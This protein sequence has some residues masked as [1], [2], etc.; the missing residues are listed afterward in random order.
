MDRSR[1]QVALF[2]DGDNLRGQSWGTL[3]DHAREFGRLAIARLYMDFQILSDGGAAARAA[4][5]EPVHVLG[6]K[7]SDGFK[8]MVDVALACDAMSVLHE[9]ENITTL[10]VG[11]GDADF[12]PLVVN[13]K[14]HGKHTVVMANGAQLANELRQVADDVVE[15]GGGRGRKRP[16]RDST[17]SRKKLKTVLLDIAGKTRLTDRETSQPMIRVDWLMEELVDQFP[18]AKQHVADE[19]ALGDLL[20]RDF[21]ELEPI[22]ARS[23]YFLLGTGPQMR[24]EEAPDPQADERV[25]EIFAE[26]CREALPPGTEWMS[27]SALFNEG[28]RLL[29]DGT[30]MEL[31]RNRPTGW[32][33]SL[34]EETD[35]VEVRIHDGGQLQA[36]REG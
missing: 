1:E 24:A 36:R 15:F 10:I 23:R 9:N 20:R 6:K 32:F 26:L 21:P 35:G 18:G 4:G 29:E 11:S 16:D 25:L 34:L 30:G 7:S 17:I 2:I 19:A 33:R 22:D 12:I 8:S 13:W 5:F 14:R 28:K 3:L 27:A 31:P